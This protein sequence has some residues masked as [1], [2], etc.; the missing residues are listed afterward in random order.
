MISTAQ[1]IH[2]IDAGL[3]VDGERVRSPQTFEEALRG[4]EFR[5][6][7]LAWIGL[8]RPTPAQVKLLCEF[9]RF[10]ESAALEALRT[11]HRSKIKRYG[12]TLYLA[13]TIPRYVDAREDVEFGELHVL[14]GPRYV[15]T[16]RQSEAPDLRVARRKLEA[17]PADLALGPEAV[18]FAILD[19]VVDEDEDV[20]GGLERDV[21]EIEAEVFRG[22]PDVSRRIYL[23]SREVIDFQRS[24]WALREII[25]D[26]QRGFESYG[27]PKSLQRYLHGVE[28]H[29][30]HLIDRTEQT[31]D[32]LRDML[33][34]N[35]TMISQEQNR[36]MT[37][38]SEASNRQNEEVKKISAW[39]AIIFAPSLVGTVYGMNFT[40]M[41]ELNWRYGYLMA[42]GLM[43]ATSATLFGL[44]KSRGWL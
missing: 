26:L 16:V 43:V 30:E 24:T 35:A 9:F 8:Y 3:Y 13:L 32:L 11:H 12:D 37:T 34:V 2:V 29:L 39:A 25:R 36:E 38:L 7:A 17:R 10:D 5:P 20:V 4:L 14:M 33:T 6:D 28:D 21:V 15:I 44:F 27:T 19:R 23:L 22:K 40:Q 42:L 31:R 1:G 41:P 18:L